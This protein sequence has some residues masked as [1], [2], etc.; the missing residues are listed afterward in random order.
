MNFEFT[1]LTEVSDGAKCESCFGRNLC[2]DGSKTCP[3]N[4]QSIVELITNNEICVENTER[5]LKGNHLEVN[6]SEVRFNESPTIN[7]QRTEIVHI[8][9]PVK[10]FIKKHN[11][12]INQ[13][14]LNKYADISTIASTPELSTVYLAQKSNDENWYRAK[15]CCKSNGNKVPMVFIDYGSKHVVNKTK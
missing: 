11:Y 5:E 15:V 2:A 8:E 10:F 3:D 13:M 4:D 12:E 1:E 14:E 9:S 6:T 7:M